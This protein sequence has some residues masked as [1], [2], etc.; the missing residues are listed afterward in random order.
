VRAGTLSFLLTKKK[1]GE[2]ANATQAQRRKWKVASN[3]RKVHLKGDLH[4]KDG[5][6]PREAKPLA[7]TREKRAG[8]LS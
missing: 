6:V 7:P 8:R 1:E 2:I 3:E 4:L 5:K